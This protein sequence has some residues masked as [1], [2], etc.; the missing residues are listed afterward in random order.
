MV[1]IIDILNRLESTS[2][3]NEKESII[4]EYG[5]NEDFKKV[6]KSAMD[7]MIT[8][9]MSKLPK[10]D[11]NKDAGS[12]IMG[13][14]SI[15]LI[16]AV[17]TAVSQFA[18]RN[19]TGNRA[20]Q[21][22]VELIE[23]IEPKEERE[24]FARVIKKDLRCGVKESTINNAFGYEF[25]YVHPNLLCSPYDEKDVTKL[26]AKV[27][28]A[29]KRVICQMKSDGARC[30]IV[31][32]PNHVFAFT[33]KGNLLD[34]EGRLDRLMQ[35][36][37]LH[38]MV[39]DGELLTRT[40]GVVDNRQT[41]N[42]IVNT[43]IQGTITP[44]DLDKVFMTAWDI[45]PYENMKTKTPY[46]VP[47]EQRLEQLKNV[48]ETLSVSTNSK[49]ELIE[50]HSV[51]TIEE[52]ETIYNK[53]M[54]DGHEGAILKNPDMIWD[55]KRSKDAIKIKAEFEG[56]FRVVGFEYGEPGKQFEHALGGLIV[57]TECKQLR[58]KI[59]KGFSEQ[60]RLTFL[61]YGNPDDM[62]GANLIV[63]IGYNSITKSKDKDTSALFLEKF[64]KIRL[65]KNEA[66][67]LSELKG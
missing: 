26:F 55:D 64:I 21:L 63:E 17:D 35:Y 13:D 6:I 53:W 30:Q 15:T 40:N 44:E 50:Y 11:A 34:F 12:S 25:I 43:L 8:F 62:I 10:Y 48:T 38:G 49:I 39:I 42:G 20:K 28:K 33:R 5:D 9:Y 65:D 22:F 2:S 46:S 3:R 19:V 36:E 1:K 57:E 18:T 66:N 31:I 41:C 37:S 7:P 14:E 32:L 23:S 58:T 47:Y 16:E 67:K 54:A 52:A 29:N 60:D 45:F 61:G 4:S 27:K 24:V 56:E 51:D 59:G